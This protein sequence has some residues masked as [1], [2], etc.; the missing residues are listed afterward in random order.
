LSAGSERASGT[1]SSEG[2]IGGEVKAGVVS[3]GA[4]LNIKNALTVLVGNA[5][6]AIRNFFGT[7]RCVQTHGC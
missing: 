3:V 4:S 2:E 5:V 1:A 7:L 6:D